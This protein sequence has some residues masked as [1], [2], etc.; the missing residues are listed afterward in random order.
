MKYETMQNLIYEYGYICRNAGRVHPFFDAA[1][2]RFFNSGLQDSC[3]INETVPYWYFVTSERCPWGEFPRLYSVRCFNK[4]TGDIDT[5]G[6]F[7][8]YKTSAA[9]TK[10]A[11]RLASLT[12]QDIKEMIAES[13]AV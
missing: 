13:E 2:M 9:A 3:Y 4:M 7:Q 10:E 11:K 5:I 6:E 8:Q 12:S 1:T